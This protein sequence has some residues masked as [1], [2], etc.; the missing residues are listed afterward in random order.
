MIFFSRKQQW[1]KFVCTAA[2]FKIIDVNEIGVLFF[3]D[4]LEYD[5]PL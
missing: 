2:L 5:M 4:E 1:T 3:L